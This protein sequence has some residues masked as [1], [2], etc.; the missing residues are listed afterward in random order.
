G[1][2]GDVAVE[3]KVAGEHRQ[4]LQR[5]LGGIGDEDGVAADLDRELRGADDGR[6]D[7]LAGVPY[8]RQVAAVGERM[9]QLLGEVATEIAETPALPPVEIFRNPPGKRHWRDRRSCRRR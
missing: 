9:A 1:V 2:G 3:R 7:A 4:V 6:A 8:R 5:Q